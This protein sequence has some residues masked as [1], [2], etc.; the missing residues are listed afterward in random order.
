MLGLELLLLLPEAQLRAVLAH[1]L[2]HVSGNHAR[3]SSWIYRLRQTW[4][5]LENAFHATQAWGTGWIQ[6]FMDWYAPY[7]AGYSYVLARDNEYEADSIAAQLTNP[8]IAA[9]ALVTVHVYAELTAKRFWQPLYRQAYTRAR[10]E[11]QVYHLLQHF[12]QQKETHAGEFYQCLRYVLTEKANAYDTHPTLM[13]RLK[14]LK[15]TGVKMKPN[16][17]TSVH[18][19]GEWA[20]TVLRHFNQEWLMQNADQWQ[21]FYQRAQA[22]RQTINTLTARPPETLSAA[23]RWQLA[24]LTDAYLPEVDALPLFE[25]YA[26]DFPD[27]VQVALA[28]GR[29]RLERDDSSGITYLEQAMESPRLQ[30]LAAELAWQYCQRQ[31][32]TPLAE[33]WLKRL[34]AARDIL[35]AAQWERATLQTGDTCEAVDEHDIPAIAMVL[36]ETVLNHPKVKAVWLARKQ[37]HYFPDDPVWVVGVQAA[38]LVWDAEALQNTLASQ[39]NLPVTVF[40]VV[41]RHNKKLMRQIKKV[42]TRLS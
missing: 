18:W 33:L 24:T 3:F 31:R 32:Q 12:F 39:L 20:D 1:E 5:Q 34:E 25:Q 10:P 16:G 7:F 42:G 35:T 21:Q 4:L 27:D 14:A 36:Q 38:W 22:A 2:A 8:E 19:L 41:D 29:L 26:Q 15:A 13:A 9:S 40:V 23:E 6:R 28:I 11:T 30:A 17:K 37:V